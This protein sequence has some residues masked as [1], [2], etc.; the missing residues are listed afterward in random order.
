MKSYKGC[1]LAMTELNQKSVRERHL[2]KPQVF[3]NQSIFF[4]SK[5]Y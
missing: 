5:A 1:T 3:G 4:N 2:E